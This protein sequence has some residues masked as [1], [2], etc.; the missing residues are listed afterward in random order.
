[1]DCTVS[2]K[3]CNSFRRNKQSQAMMRSAFC[4]VD[5][6]SCLSAGTNQSSAAAE[7]RRRRHRRRHRR[8]RNRSIPRQTQV[9]PISSPRHSLMASERTELRT[10]L[11]CL[12][13]RQCDVVSILWQ[14]RFYLSSTDVQ[15]S[16]RS[17][18]LSPYDQRSHTSSPSA[19][20]TLLA[21]SVLSR[22]AAPK[23]GERARAER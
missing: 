9:R 1:M 13:N 11:V 5:W 21:L 18:H 7:T 10:L 16:L 3:G 17:A 22:I 2:R 12:V 19:L 14:S 4:S 20:L 15:S 8:R 6:G 23:T